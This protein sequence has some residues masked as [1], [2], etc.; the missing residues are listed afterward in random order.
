MTLFSGEAK[1]S[2]TVVGGLSV[3]VNGFGGF[4]CV[5]LC[6]QAILYTSLLPSSFSSSSLSSSTSS[7]SSSSS[8]FSSS[9][10]FFSSFYSSSSFLLQDTTDVQKADVIL[11][12]HSAVV[13]CHFAPGA[14]A[15]GCA[16]KILIRNTS[17]GINV[18]ELLRNGSSSLV[19]RGQISLP[20]GLSPSD[21]LIHICVVGR[22]GVFCPVS[23]PLTLH[24]QPTPT[25]TT[26]ML[27]V[28]SN[29][30]QNT[31]TYEYVH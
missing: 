30:S 23:I 26:G 8:S 28:S 6:I 4:S 1:L 29:P 14:S 24:T 3:F 5:L 21:L 10:T 27:S 31:C 9:S 19:V 7:S 22:D 2:L 12:Q 25:L 20:Q 15:K 16:V 13:T 11:S 17:N 18:T